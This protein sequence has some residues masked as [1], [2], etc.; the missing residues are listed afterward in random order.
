[1]MYGYGFDGWGGGGMIGGL[2]MMVLF[3]GGLIALVVILVRWLDRDSRGH[4]GSTPPR[5]AALHLLEERFARGDIDKDEFME[6]K[7]LLSDR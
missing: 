6:R 5:S 4:F 3:W 1:M 7:R 2:F